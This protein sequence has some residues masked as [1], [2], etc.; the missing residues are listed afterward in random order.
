MQCLRVQALLSSEK[1]K[2]GP[3]IAAVKSCAMAGSLY[4]RR[5]SADS[6]V[7]CSAHTNNYKLGDSRA[8]FSDLASPV[9]PHNSPTF[10]ENEETSYYDKSLIP[11]DCKPSFEFVSSKARLCILCHAAN[12]TFDNKR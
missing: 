12:F 5:K 1:S 3:R 9:R 11:M 10:K 8:R 7:Q 6:V 4:V 2:V